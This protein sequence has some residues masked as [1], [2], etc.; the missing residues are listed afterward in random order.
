MGPGESAGPD[1]RSPARSPAQLRSELAE[2]RHHLQEIPPHHGGGRAAMQRR[3]A[4]LERELAATPR[5]TRRA[6]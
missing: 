3:I 4:A 2:L 5:T 6:T 1:E